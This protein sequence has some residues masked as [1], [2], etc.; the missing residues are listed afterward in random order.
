[1]VTV[2]RGQAIAAD[3]AN[4]RRHLAKTYVQSKQ[5]YA[6]KIAA[7]QD[8]WRRRKK[9]HTAAAEPVVLPVMDVAGTPP[10][11]TPQYH[12]PFGL[13]VT[14]ARIPA[15]EGMLPPSSDQRQQLSQ[16]E[17][18]EQASASAEMQS[19]VDAAVKT[20]QLVWLQITLAVFL[21]VT[22]CA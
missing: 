8:R 17:L 22:S 5:R 4:V 3:D 18:D 1:M 15:L 20:Q 19:D 6:D 12:L 13:S 11:P 21:A 10:T 7:K 2:C 14:S 9:N 16:A